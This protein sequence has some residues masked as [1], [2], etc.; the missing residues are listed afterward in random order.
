MSQGC[1]KYGTREEIRQIEAT[2]QPELITK[3]GERGFRK[4]NNEREIRCVAMENV[5]SELGNKANQK[6]L[7]QGQIPLAITAKSESSKPKIVDVYTNKMEKLTD[8]TNIL[9]AASERAAKKY[10]V[11]PIDPKDVYKK[12]DPN[13]PFPDV[14]DP[15]IKTI[16][17][18]NSDFQKTI[19]E[20]QAEA[21]IFQE[22][23]MEIFAFDIKNTGFDNIATYLCK[24]K[25]DCVVIIEAKCT[26][27]KDGR[28]DLKTDAHGIKQ[29]SKR[30]VQARLV[31]MTEPKSRLYSETNAIFA[32]AAL[33][34]VEDEQLDRYLIH[35]N[36]NTLNIIVSKAHNDEEW[37]Y[38]SAY[39]SLESER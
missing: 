15:N 39:R 14:I 25:N 10:Y 26:Q 6:A 34:K 19:G 23:E 2:R 35:T 38:L 29:A 27:S 8:E 37:Q 36:V 11:T 12:Y 31:T 17:S 7:P 33:K 22:L 30:W 24:D 3:I 20:K 13:E 16:D 28:S 32:E 9:Q 5:R 21:L 4:A 1:V 18:D